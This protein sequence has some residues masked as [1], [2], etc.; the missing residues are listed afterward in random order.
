MRIFSDISD[1]LYRVTTAKV[2]VAGLAV[3]IIFSILVLPGQLTRDD[4]AS[5]VSDIPD[6]SFYY[7]ADDLY[8]MA[9]EY[10][11]EGRD[12]YVWARFTFDLI[13]PIVYGV[14]LA[15]TITWFFTQIFP[16]GSLWQRVNILPILG[17]L[18]DYLEN[19]STSLVVVRYPGQTPIVDWLAGVFTCVKW[20]FIAASL[21]C[22]IYGGSM[23][24]A[25]R[26]RERSKI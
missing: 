9:G 13:W 20:I 18:F 26:F 5:P 11:Q 14:F 23:Y 6:L 4:D 12:A 15:T 8:R 25:Q 24:L 22:L 16:A 10:G 7:S 3:F 2:V 19:L 21:I 17:M 1:W